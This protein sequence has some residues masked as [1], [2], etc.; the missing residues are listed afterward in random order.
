VSVKGQGQEAEPTITE[1]L[2]RLDSRGKAYLDAGSGC[3]G[4]EEV[5]ELLVVDLQVRH[6][7]EEE[8]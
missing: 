7:R 2:T 3:G 8:G 4:A 1:A 5:A 6:L